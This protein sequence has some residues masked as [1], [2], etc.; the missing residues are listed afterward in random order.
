M[1]NEINWNYQFS[2]PNLGFYYFSGWVGEIENKD[3][4][5]PTEVEIRTEFGKKKWVLLA[6]NQNKKMFK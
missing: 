5:S 2:K 6:Q 3:Q 1:I 4:L